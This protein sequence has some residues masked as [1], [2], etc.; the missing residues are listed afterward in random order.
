VAAIA[1]TRPGWES[2]V[3]SRTPLRPRA[4][5]GG[6]VLAGDDVQAERFAVAA[7][8]DRDRV[9]D[10]DVHRPATLATLDDE[11]VE[12]HVGVGAAVERAGAEVLDDLVEA[13]RQPGDLALRHPLDPEL[14]HQLL[15]PTR[16]DAGEVRVGDHRHERLLRPPARLQQPLR[17]VR[18]LAQLRQRELD[19]ADP[20]VPIPLPITVAAVDS[21]RTPLAVARAA[22]RVRL[23]AHQR[24]RE[25]L[26]HRP[27]QIQACLLELLAQPTRHVH[28]VLDHRRPPRF[29][30]PKPTREDDAVVSCSP[31]RGRRSALAYGTLS[32]AAA[33]DHPNHALHHEGGRYS[34]RLACRLA[35]ARLGLEPVTLSLSIRT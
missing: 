6:A 3:T 1:S 23:R 28:R 2:L 13:L 18:P 10:A 11:R 8:V 27:Q 33:E 20:G 19:R 4:T 16:G 9:H 14:L 31:A 26:D 29:V 32:T 30:V 35:P 5:S 34:V 15:D 12:G 17:K 25:V 21:L 24:L 7:A 22:E